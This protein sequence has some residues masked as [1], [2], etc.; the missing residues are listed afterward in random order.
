MSSEAE[1]SDAIRAAASRAGARLWRNNVGAMY[2]EHRRLVR[3]GLANES[4]QMSGVVKSGDLVGITPV[5]IVPGHVGMTLGVFTS[6]EVKKTGW[7]YKGTGRELAQKNWNDFII[8]LG[9]IGMF[10]TSPVEA[11]YL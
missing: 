11:G 7:V 6:I 9:G 10:A 4:A 3:Y 5:L 2:D 1:N 8:N